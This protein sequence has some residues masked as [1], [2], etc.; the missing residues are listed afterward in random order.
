MISYIILI[1]VVVVDGGGFYEWNHTA[2][3]VFKAAARPLARVCG[4]WPIFTT[5]FLHTYNSWENGYTEEQV[6]VVCDLLE[7]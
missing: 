7:G 4:C 3:A 5:L 1:C 2:A 6:L